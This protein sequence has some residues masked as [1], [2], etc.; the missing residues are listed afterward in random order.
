VHK[1]WA[2]NVVKQIPIAE[3]QTKILFALGQIMY[4]RV[5]PLDMI[6]FCG[7]NYK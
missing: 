6:L 7:C 5:H 4:S 1:T 2:K 3:D